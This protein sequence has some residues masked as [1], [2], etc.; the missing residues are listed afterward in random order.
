M[1]KVRREGR[2]EG[3]KVVTERWMDGWMNEWIDRKEYIQYMYIYIY[4][5][6]TS[7]GMSPSLPY[8]AL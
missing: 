1:R 8:D 3:R 6:D 7:S 4:K 2:K 5:L